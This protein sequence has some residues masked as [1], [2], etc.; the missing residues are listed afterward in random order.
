MM[1]QKNLLKRKTPHYNFFC[2]IVAAFHL[3]QFHSHVSYPWGGHI[4]W[5]LKEHNL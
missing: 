5:C 4:F 2:A 3:A 1:Q